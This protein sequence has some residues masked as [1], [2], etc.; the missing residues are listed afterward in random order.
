MA[1]GIE[2][3]ITIFGIAIGIMGLMLIAG[4]EIRDALKG[5]TQSS[6]I[7][8]TWRYEYIPRRKREMGV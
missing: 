3:F 1:I 8:D 2:M 4:A 5:E 7:R 6:S